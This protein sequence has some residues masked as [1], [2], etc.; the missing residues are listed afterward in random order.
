[1]VGQV[2]SEA[3][4]AQRQ[5]GLRGKVGSEARW[6]P[7]TF[8]PAPA[9]PPPPPRPSPA[10]LD[11]GGVDHSAPAGGDPA[12]QQADLVQRRPLVD[13]RHALLVH[14]AVLAERGRAHE[15]EDGGAI[16]GGEARLAIRL[17]HTLT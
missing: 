1:V 13:Q 9:T 3:R 14:H 6:Q 2:G 4:W 17:H 8:R 15:V 5:G 12:A 7:H 11:F 10:H 16:Q